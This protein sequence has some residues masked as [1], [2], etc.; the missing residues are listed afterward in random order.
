MT[1]P[2]ATLVLTAM[3]S[4]EK[5]FIEDCK[6]GRNGKVRAA[7]IRGQRHDLVDIYDDGKSPLH[8]AAENGHPKV[9]KLLIV[10]GANVEAEDRWQ[11]RPL[12]LA[13]MNGH[14]LA[15]RV[16]L[17]HGAKIEARHFSALH[18]AVPHEG[19]LRL[20]LDYGGRIDYREENGATALIAAA[21]SGHADTVEILLSRR[22]AKEATDEFGRTALHCSA[23]NG[24]GAVAK[25]LLEYGS[26]ALARTLD[27]RLPS[28]M[29][30]ANVDVRNLLLKAE[31]TARSKKSALQVVFKNSRS[32]TGGADGTDGREYE[33]EQPARRCKRLRGGSECG[34]G[35]GAT[36]KEEKSSGASDRR[37]SSASSSSSLTCSHHSPPP[38]SPLRE[39]SNH[40]YSFRK[41]PRT[42]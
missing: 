15:V 31:A 1:S 42:V 35:S 24:H 19:V 21:E 9:A 13:C 16:L 34:S 36:D 22:A 20:L 39:A 26:N 41:R 14:L 8:H 2:L 5:L 38:A 17:F 29:A 33:R 37:R 12:D 4:T 25:V 27:G 28:D 30:G 18:Y 10:A 32:S 23:E 40:S 11:G 7:L 3:D 6:L